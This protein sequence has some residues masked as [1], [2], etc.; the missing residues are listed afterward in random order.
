MDLETNPGTAKPSAITATQ[1]DQIQAGLE[2]VANDWFETYM[3]GY[4]CWPYQH[5]PVKIVGWAVGNKSSL[6]FTDSTP[7]YVGQNDGGGVPECAQSCGRFFHQDG[8]YGACPGGAANHYDMS[9]WLTNGMG[10]GGAGGDWGQRV[11]YDFTLSG[12]AAGSAHIVSHEFGHGLGLPDFYSGGA[13]DFFTIEASAGFSQTSFVMMA[14][15]STQVTS[16]DGW[17]AR[18]HWFKFIKDRY[19]Y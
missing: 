1:R 7:V 12:F 5:I 16:F 8:N 13:Q 19:K 3:K 6:G 10:M 4:D 11:D 14:G 2:K 15:S 9:L 18:Q 17:M